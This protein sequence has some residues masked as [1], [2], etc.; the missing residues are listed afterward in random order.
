MTST[1]KSKIILDIEGDNLYPGVTTL[2][3]AV[4]IDIETNVETRFYPED[5][6]K[7][8]TDYLD[9]CDFIACHHGVG[10]DFPALKAVL[11]W[12]PKERSYLFDTL[13]MSKA[14]MCDRPI[15]YGASS[16]HSVDAWG[17][18]MGIPKPKHEDWSKYSDEMMHRCAEDTRIQYNMFKM[19]CIEAGFDIKYV[20]PRNPKGYRKNG[21]TWAESMELEHKSSFI[22]QQQEDNGVYFHAEQAEGHVTLLTGYAEKQGKYIL[23]QT[24]MTARQWGGVPVNRP[25]LKN[26]HYSSPVL[27]WYSAV[28]EGDMRN[29]GGP[30]TRIEWHTLNLNSPVQ[31]KEWLFSIGW[32]PDTWN[33]KKNK[34]GREIK[35]ENGVKTPTSPKITQ[36]SLDLI[37]GK[38]G[39]CISRR[40]KANHKKNQ[41]QGF[42]D[43]YDPE[44]SRIRA[45]AD[46]QGTPTK[47]MRHRVVANIPKV[48][49]HD[50]KLV[51]FPGKQDPFYG[52]EMRSLF[53]CPEGR[54]LLG[55]DAAG[56]ELR[57]LAHFM[58]DEEYTNILLSGDIHMH[59]T[60]LAGLPSRAHGKSFIYA[61]N[62]GAGAWK[63]GSIVHPNGTDE[64]RERE[65][66]R[67]KS[68]FLLACPSITKLIKSVTKAAGRGYL[69]ALDNSKLHIR[70]DDTGR[71]ET[72]KALNTLLQGAGSLIMTYARIWLHEEI[73]KRKQ[74]RKD[75][76]K[77]LDYHDE[78]TYELSPQY[79]EE[80]SELMIESVVQAGI[81]FNFN[82]PL[83]ADAQAGKSWAE[84]H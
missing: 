1:S 46:V 31:M 80:L 82:L 22:M 43:R 45:G 29:V 34:R 76:M 70:R 48:T 32:V 75:V 39:R 3:C 44:N 84:I 2:W 73:E 30:F 38:L 54:I 71:L 74:L 37:D 81:Y 25:F 8:F 57:C 68:T 15:P 63:L 14:L 47:R 55:R 16:P 62:Y 17:L 77:V 35:D 36:S 49:T 50:K 4:A 10:F 79:E 20:D 12:E 52:T 18:R 83:D 19:L 51:W 7:T 23:D 64:E 9:G 78:E 58:N 61:F 60:T 59:N 33:Y 66:K 11:G 21:V 65:G 26:G 5:M 6:N 56:L 72:Y 67:M 28:D 69:K 41:I 53:G 13:I 42:L 40:N 24:P 27:R